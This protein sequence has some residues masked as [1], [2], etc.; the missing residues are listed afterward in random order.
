MCV[1]VYTHTHTHIHIYIKLNHFAVHRKLTQHCKL[2]T[3]QEKKKK[4]I[5]KMGEPKKHDAK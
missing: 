1:Y 3:L 4:R 5:Q 2:T